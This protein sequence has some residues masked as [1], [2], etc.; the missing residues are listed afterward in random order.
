MPLETQGALQAG[1]SQPFPLTC[2][3]VFSH[4]KPEKPFFTLSSSFHFYLHSF[5]HSLILLAAILLTRFLR[6]IIQSLGNKVLHGRC[7]C[8]VHGQKE[9]GRIISRVIMFFYRKKQ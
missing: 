6:L 1:P 9:G 2:F 7:A 4:S 8:G 5:I 3:S